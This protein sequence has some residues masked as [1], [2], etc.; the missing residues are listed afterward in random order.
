MPIDR[1]DAKILNVVQVDNRVSCEAIGDKVGLSHTA[2]VR[3]LKR[4]RRDR[5]ILADIA[6]VSA[7]AVGFP[8]RVTLLCS[9]ERDTPDAHER[10]LKAVVTDP[11]VVG[12]ETV[13]GAADMLLTVLA[14]SN[15]D[16]DAW[17]QDLLARF[18]NLK[19]VSSFIS[20]RQV[21]AGA[22][23]LVEPG[24]GE[25]TAVGRTGGRR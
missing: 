15:D 12:V 8:V 9:V 20:L 18:P 1:L 4:L 21:K 3:R 22:P 16:Y 13:L 19:N 11:L 24:R 7:R 14:R 10:F 2:V 6:L 5:V 17:L 23:V 25:A